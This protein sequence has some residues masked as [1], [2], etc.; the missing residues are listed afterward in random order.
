M[1][2][3]PASSSGSIPRLCARWSGLPESE[4]ALTPGSRCMTDSAFSV[5][6]RT[7]QPP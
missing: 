7:N 1:R 4:D 3:E 6:V 5:T 2:W